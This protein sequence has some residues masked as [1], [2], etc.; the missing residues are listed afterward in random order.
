MI[1]YSQYTKYYSDSKF[2]KKLNSYAKKAGIELCYVALL[3]YYLALD[4]TSIPQIQN[5]NNGSFRIL[6]TSCRYDS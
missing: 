1:E 3:S 6:N 2:W 4:P 5:E